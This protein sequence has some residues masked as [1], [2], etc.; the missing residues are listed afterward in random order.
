MARI[1]AAQPYG[2]GADG[3]HAP[4]IVFGLEYIVALRVEHRQ[5]AALIVRERDIRLENTVFLYHNGSPV[6][7]VELACLSVLGDF[8][9]IARIDSNYG[10]A[11]VGFESRG[12]ALYVGPVVELHRQP[13][14]KVLYG[15]NAVE[16]VEDRA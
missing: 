11:P 5:Y 3:L 4:G 6:E 2:V 7:I 9:I 13:G 8:L 12:P 1:A 15:L 10:I 16:F 14:G